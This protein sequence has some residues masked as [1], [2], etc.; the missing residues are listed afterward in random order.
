MVSLGLRLEGFGLAFWN[1]VAPET[2][3]DLL[4]GDSILCS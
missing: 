4:G 3:C 1:A 2:P